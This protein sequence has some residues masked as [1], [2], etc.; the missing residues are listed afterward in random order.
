M[1]NLPSIVCGHVLNP[2]RNDIILDMCAAPGNKTTHLATIINNQVKLKKK[3]LIILII[4]I[5]KLV[6]GHN[7]CSG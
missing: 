1:Q 3:F 4:L 7:Y 6:L 5:L 2:Q